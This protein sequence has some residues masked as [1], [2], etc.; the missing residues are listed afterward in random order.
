MSLIKKFLLASTL[1]SAHAASCMEPATAP[2]IT[3]FEDD[4]H[5]WTLSLGGR[6]AE[7][8]KYKIVAWRP[9]DEELTEKAYKMDT[10]SP[11]CYSLLCNHFG[12]T[13]FKLP[14]TL[15]LS[16]ASLS[17]AYDF[18]LDDTDGAIAMRLLTLSEARNWHNA[19]KTNKVFD[20]SVTLRLNNLL[21]SE[22]ASYFR[23][24]TRKYMWEWQ[25]LLHLGSYDP[26]SP[27]SCLPKELLLPL[28]QYTFNAQVQEF[29]ENADHDQVLDL[30]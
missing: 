20:L 8:F 12:P 10:Q 3:R 15:S 17:R 14:V 24:Q 16:R 29:M 13:L 6:G 21:P 30:Q 5:E 1:C 19:V 22:R 28:T 4:A 25:R 9:Q 18:D 2:V 11:I 26:N 7:A 23:H 27:L